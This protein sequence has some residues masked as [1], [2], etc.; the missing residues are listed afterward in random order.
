[1]VGQPAA[2]GRNFCVPLVELGGQK[3]LHGRVAVQRE[4]AEIVSSLGMD[5]TIH[6]LLPV[7]GKDIRI[8]GVLA[9]V[10]PLDHAGAIGR[11]PEEIVS[12]VTGR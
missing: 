7:R 2:V 4:H 8:L 12:S 10:E 3:R 9:L 6:Q 5:L 11:F 1:M